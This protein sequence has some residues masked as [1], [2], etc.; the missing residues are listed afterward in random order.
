MET[1]TPTD[2]EVQLTDHAGRPLKFQDITV[3]RE[4][5]QKY[6]DGLVEHWEEQTT[7]VTRF[8]RNGKPMVKDGKVRQDAV[9]QLVKVPAKSPTVTGLAMA[10]GSGRKLLIEYEDRGLGENATQFERDFRNTIKAAKETIQ[11]FNEELL[12]GG[13]PAAGVIFSLKNNWGWVDK[14]EVEASGGH[15]VTIEK[16]MSDA[17]LAD[18]IARTAQSGRPRDEGQAATGASPQEP[19]AGT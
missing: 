10:M 15:K 5:V 18:L 7:Y 16:E 3:V 6:F 13:A 9:T 4:L 8:G 17:E 19:G 1:Q 12:S 14:S 2:Q 11:V